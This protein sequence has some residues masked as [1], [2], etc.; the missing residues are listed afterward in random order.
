MWCVKRKPGTRD[1]ERGLD[2]RA[3]W[4]GE[5]MEFCGLEEEKGV[6]DDSQA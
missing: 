3:L 2:S 4:A 1:G 5:L 6:Q